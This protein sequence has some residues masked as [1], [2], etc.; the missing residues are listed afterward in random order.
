M[1]AGVRVRWYDQ[2]IGLLI[3]A[4][5]V[6]LLVKTAP[7]LGYAR[8]EGF[9]F[10]AAQS[11]A[12]WFQEL[13]DSPKQAV[14][15]V[16]VDRV[17]SAN[18]E[19]P[20]LAKSAFAISWLVFYKKWHLFAEEGT[21]FRFPGMVSAGAALWILYLWGAR[22]RSREVGLGAA[23]AFALMPRVFYHSHLDC[24]DIPITT[25]WLA[26]SYGYW[27]SIQGGGLRWAVLTGIL[28][29]LALSTK[30]NSWF[31]PIAFVIHTVWMHVGLLRHDLRAGT[32]R[33]PTALLFMAI[34]GP[35]VFYATWPW[36]WFDTGARLN[37]YVGF[38]MGHEYYNMEFFGQTYWKP[39]MPRTYPWVMTAATVP[40]ITLVCMLIG[41]GHFVWE[42]RRRPLEMQGEA[43]TG[44]LW[45]VGIFIN[46]APWLSSSTP[47]FGGTKHWITAYP[48]LALFAGEGIRW[49]LRWAAES[50][51]WVLSHPVWGRALIGLAC[52]A[53]PLVQTLRSHPWGLS[54][55]TPLVGGAAGAASLGLNRG[56]W[57]F[58]TGSVLP[59]INE[60]APRGASVYIHDTAYQSWEMFVRD[61]RVRNDLRVSYSP[62][63]GNYG[64][65]HHEQHMEGVECQYWVSYGTAAPA[66]IPLFDGVPVVWVYERPGTRR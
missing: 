7:T 53:S 20:A 21:S 39:P 41:L 24:F 8:D 15:R 5:Y 42:R 44:T 17:W 13:W 36:I 45:I 3:A 64:I 48:F 51:M 31:L 35:L 60:H 26:C 2:A 54:N 57:G 52:A 56:F 33:I 9:Y 65:Y 11:Y 43:V 25:M 38:H 4:L 59:W 49:V 66:R 23:L 1:S 18:H 47:I 63:D 62:A 50:K 37:D 14:T 22:A 6:V 27:R 61:G 28:F 34:L 32:F 29:G 12:S 19:H 55:Y 58:T 16:A 40:I 10:S 30:H 46:Y